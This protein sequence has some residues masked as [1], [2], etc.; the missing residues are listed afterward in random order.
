MKRD[1]FYQSPWM[2]GTDLPLGG[3]NFTIAKLTTE[4][5]GQ[6]RESMPIMD[7]EE[8][9]KRLILKKRQWGSLWDLLGADKKGGNSHWPGKSIRLTPVEVETPNGPKL[10][11][12]ISAATDDEIAFEEE[13]A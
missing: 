13:T 5:I 4:E 3:A 2:K 1:D 6:D 11:I 12:R 7:V 9:E 10:T 8:S